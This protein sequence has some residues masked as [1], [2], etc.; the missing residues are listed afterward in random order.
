MDDW[1]KYVRR[2]VLWDGEGGCNRI[3]V[4]HFLGHLHFEHILWGEH[5]AHDPV[6][7]GDYFPPPQGE[8]KR[9]AYDLFGLRL[10]DVRWELLDPETCDDW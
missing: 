10:A 7:V 1:R 9:W 2:A 6:D 5:I 3:A 4:E 8:V